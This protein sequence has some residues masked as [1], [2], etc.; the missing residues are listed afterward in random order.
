MGRSA[1]RRRATI[2]GLRALCCG[3]LGG[4]LAACSHD[5]RDEAQVGAMWR[6][7]RI[8]VVGTLTDTGACGVLVD[9]QGRRYGIVGNLGRFARGDRLRVSGPVAYWSGCGTYSAVRAERVERVR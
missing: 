2:T 6:D 5:A 7:L 8:E 1:K 9:G 3:L 4:F